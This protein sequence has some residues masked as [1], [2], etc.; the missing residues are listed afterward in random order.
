MQI[1]KVREKPLSELNLKEALNLYC[2]NVS[3]AE[4]VKR[5]RGSEQR[6]FK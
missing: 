3:S 2:Y 4:L 1:P 5:I 6:Y